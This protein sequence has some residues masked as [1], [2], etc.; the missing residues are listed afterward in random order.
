MKLQVY[1]EIMTI[2]KIKCDKKEYT[3]ESIIGYTYNSTDYLYANRFSDNLKN[4]IHYSYL[5]SF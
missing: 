3:S 2:K 1:T 5:K 4:N